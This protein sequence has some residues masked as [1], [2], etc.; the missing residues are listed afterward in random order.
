[1]MK[2]L[3]KV[4]TAE[5]CL[6]MTGAIYDKP[7]ANVTL[8]GEE[9]KAP[10]QGEEQGK[11]AHSHHYCSTQYW[12]LSHSNHTRK[13]RQP[14]WKGRRET[15]AVWRWIILYI[16][17]TKKSTKNDLI[18]E[19]SKVTG[20]KMNIQ[21]SIVFLVTKPNNKK[22]KLGKQSQSQMHQEEQN[23]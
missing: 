21:K 14:N 18:K 17:N 11:P 1:M 10:P 19:F 12:G 16:E 8:S 6:N 20:Y 7:T 5:T 15:V 22:E 23:A 13:R 2:T 9:G 3:N 4:G